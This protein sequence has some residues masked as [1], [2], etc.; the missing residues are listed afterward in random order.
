MPATLALDQRQIPISS[1][2]H[3]SDDVTKPALD[4]YWKEKVD[5]LTY[6]SPLEDLSDLASLEEWTGR[7]EFIIEDLSWLL[8]LP[9]H[10][11]WSQVMFDP[12]LQR[13]LDSY[14]R[15]APRP[16]DPVTSLPV[17]LAAR[18][19]TLHKQVF[20]TFLRMATHKESKENF[21]TPGVF[22]DFI[23]ENFLF[24]VAKLIE[25]SVLYGGGNADL[26]GKMIEN[27]FR[28]QPKFNEDLVTVVPDI[29]KIFDVVLEKCKLKPDSDNH[30]AAPPSRVLH[31]M[32]EVELRDL[33]HYITDSALSIL[34][35]LDIY[36]QGAY[37]FKANNFVSKM[38][39]FFEIMVPAFDKALKERHWEDESKKK[40]LK[41]HLH[42]GKV[43]LAK[44]CQSIVAT[45]HMQPILDN[46]SKEERSRLVEEY[47]ELMSTL[48]SD[49]YFLSVFAHQY[50]IG[51]DLDVILQKAHVDE[52]R[53]QFILDGFKSAMATKA[54]QKHAGN[55]VSLK[56]LTEV[57]TQGHVGIDAGHQYDAMPE[58]YQTDEYVEALAPSSSGACGGGVSDV[59]MA[60]LI[61]S[62]KDLF[63]EYGEGFIEACLEEYMNDS[64]Q[65]INAI[66][67]DKLVPGLRDLN[68]TMERTVKK[69][70]PQVK[71]SAAP[72]LLQQR[73]NIYQNDEFDVFSRGTVDTNKIHKGKRSEKLGT[74]LNDKTHLRSLRPMYE[75]YENEYDDEYD[76]TYDANDVGAGD[77]DSADELTARRPFMVPRVLRETQDN[78]SGED[79]NQEPPPGRNANR[80]DNF[81]QPTAP[82]PQGTRGGGRGAS[83]GAVQG[84]GKGRGQTKETQRARGSKEK[85]KGRGANHNRKA[86]ADKK[87]SK[88]MLS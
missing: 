40:S 23:Y 55:D 53:A 47:L 74:L 8:K 27:I 30:Q 51:E 66:L 41:K 75:E 56:S 25:L 31:T 73:S 45:C 80:A 88:G 22:G 44:V 21:I 16:Y 39:A 37:A 85:N 34:A 11:F 70:Q 3:G 81:Q 76:D 78:S 4:L 59:Q 38:A 7:L 10:K 13:C 60:S 1:G 86:M 18:H 15:N 69:P 35:F 46:T 33:I 17:D 29:L 63:P 6:E 48:L 87:R 2:G 20:M 5:F 43:S 61:S 83:R 49:K 84:Q 71:T 68:K 54:K 72:S 82:R 19:R 32:P 65:V 67:E 28:Y 9:H 77:A 52:T 26:L 12:S 62:V 42:L 79:D 64:S 24:D 14:L 36:P 58:D 50:Q 57:T